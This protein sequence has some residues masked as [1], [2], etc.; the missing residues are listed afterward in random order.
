MIYYIKIFFLIFLLYTKIVKEELQKQVFLTENDLHPYYKK[1]YFQTVACYETWKNSTLNC[2]LKSMENF[3]HVQTS[4]SIDQV[5][6]TKYSEKIK[7]YIDYYER[8]V[9]Q[10]FK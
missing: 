10:V 9:N 2:L 6:E 5:I 3:T 7:S 8:I 4:F 1:E